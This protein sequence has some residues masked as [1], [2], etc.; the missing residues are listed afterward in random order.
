MTIT[1]EYA[2]IKRVTINLTKYLAS[3]LGKYNIRVNC[4][5]PG[6]IFNN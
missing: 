3:Y 2:V 6:G 1:V 4:I 5:S